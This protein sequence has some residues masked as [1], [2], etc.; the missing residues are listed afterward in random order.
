[1]LHAGIG[2]GFARQP[3]LAL[4]ASPS[5]NQVHDF[6]LRFV[7]L[8]KENS[9]P[10]YAGA[11]IES[12]GL[13]SR[14]MRG[15]EFGQQLH[16]ALSK[17][18][19]DAVG[20]FWRGAGRC[21]Y[22]HPQNFLPKFG[23]PYRG[24]DMVD[25]EAPS[26]ETKQALFSGMA[27]ALTVVNMMSPEVMESVLDT[28]ADDFAGQPGFVNGVTCS[29]VM[30][31]DTTPGDPLIARFMNHQPAKG[32]K[33]AGLWAAKIKT[34]CEFATGT[35]HPALKRHQRLE[36]VFHYQSLPELIGRLG[37]GAGR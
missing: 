1:M 22:F 35:V 33:L 26:P 4:P 17:D 15:P 25:A 19:P 8:C 9:R 31:Y 21:T 12:L 6:A 10:G 3:I 5:D 32:G 14:F 18:A 7:G 11:A 13:V 2:M 37:S 23:R 20:Y 28:L 36:E 16:R 24:L 30:R 34:S 27:W 29:V